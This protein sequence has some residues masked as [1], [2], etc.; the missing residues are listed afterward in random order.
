MQ[1]APSDRPLRRPV[2]K[3]GPL[4]KQ[5]SF[6]GPILW[7][8]LQ[9]SY[10]DITQPIHPNIRMCLTCLRFARL[11]GASW[12]Q[13]ATSTTRE[14]FRISWRHMCWH[15]HQAL[16]DRCQVPGQND[17]DSIDMLNLHLTFRGIT[18]HFVSASCTAQKEH[19]YTHTCE[20]Q[21]QPLITSLQR[22]SSETR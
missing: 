10:L 7:P 12:D 6:W 11:F 17:F 19:T 18:P 3:Q 1:S 5:A 22:Q 20:Q 8:N 15:R 2:F 14:L 21:A 4:P 9:S 13:H 16:P